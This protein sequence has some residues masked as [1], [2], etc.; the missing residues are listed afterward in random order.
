MARKTVVILEDDLDGSE[1]D[2]TVHFAVDGAQYEVDLTAGHA[3]E[4]RQA[5]IPHRPPLL[6]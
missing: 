2:E 1:A 5:L 6:L 3:H 4:L